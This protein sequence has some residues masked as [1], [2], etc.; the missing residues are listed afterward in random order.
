MTD[1]A[2]QLWKIDTTHSD[3][4]FK[5][6]HMMIS[7]VSGSF[8]NFDASAETNNDQFLNANFKFSAKI[9]S[10]N[11]NNADRDNHLKSADFFDAENHPELTFVS[12]SYDGEKLVGD[13]TIRNT[14]KEVTLDVEFNG[15]AQD[16]YGQTKA[17]FEISGDINRKDFG[18]NWN[19]V[20][21]AG[22]IVVSDKVRLNIDIQLVKQ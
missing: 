3:V 12:K 17:G 5:V 15:I 22:N 20:T 2:K 13:M 7:T 19:A 21:E 18:L 9:D 6:K 4:T 8:T 10:I 16:P 1:T 14:T 11:T